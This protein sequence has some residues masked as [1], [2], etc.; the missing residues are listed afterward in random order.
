MFWRLGKYFALKDG[1]VGPPN[2]YLGA[3]IS[4][5]VLPNGV[6]AWAWSSS[7]YIQEA[8]SNLEAQ[9][10]L[11]GH[12][13]RKGVNSPLTTGYRP[14]CDMTPEC[15]EEDSR[16]YMSLIGV[17]RWVVE[18]GRVDLTCEA[19]MLASYCAMPREGHLQQ[20]FHVF[21]SLKAQHNS[22]MVFDP[23][24]PEIDLEEFP[25]REWKQHYG[26]S[27]EQYPSGCPRP[28]GKEFLIRAFVD[29]DVAGDKLTRRS[30]T[31][32]LS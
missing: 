6:E 3:K 2:L 26:D 9:L 11:R 1:S 12:K 22:R 19:S 20:L 24:Y 29:A 27:G 21:A 8:I 25:L 31:G 13:L 30:R 7:K 4:K 32:L 17:L 18:L 15:N 5:I 16:L 28:L 23:S 14:E 10:D